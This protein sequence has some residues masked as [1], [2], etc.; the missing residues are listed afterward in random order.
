MWLYGCEEGYVVMLCSQFC[1]DRTIYWFKSYRRLAILAALA[2][3]SN[4]GWFCHGFTSPLNTKLGFGLCDPKTE[5]P[6]VERRCLGQN[7]FK[8]ANNP[9]CYVDSYAI[10]CVPH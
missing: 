5:I 10:I 6:C 4:S 1:A 7:I 9:D 8:S 3:I 2:G